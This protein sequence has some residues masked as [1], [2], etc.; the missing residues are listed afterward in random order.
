[1][2]GLVRRRVQVVAAA[3]LAVSALPIGP[4]RADDPP[5]E[6]PVQ[7]TVDTQPDAVIV[8]AETGHHTAGGTGTQ[9]SG[10]SGPQCYLREVPMSDWD[11]DFTL[12]YWRYRMQ[13][14]PWYVVCNGEV[15]SVI[16]LDISD[17]AGSAPASRDPR[18]VALELRDEM[19]V[20]RVDV[21]INPSRG[22][23]GVESW[24]W[25]DGYGG[26]PLTNSTDAFG[27]LVEVEARVTRY[28]WSFGDGAT[29]VSESPG[30]AYPQK[31]EVRHVYE[32][33]SAGLS[34]GYPVDAEFVFA[35]RYRVNGGAW[36]EL[37]GITR[38][39]HADYPVRESQAV[40]RR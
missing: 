19:S 14:E 21:E 20:P 2:E 31:S 32:R 6:D 12:Q 10:S 23:V 13:K 8:E 16:W 7:V 22:L 9:A 40:I 35:V 17:E 27:D 29:D 37:P 28:E 33:S 38:T 1:M 5:Y 18:D 36:I 25:I 15:K 30:H 26:A 39:A 34:S 11:E 3:V 4:A 24:F